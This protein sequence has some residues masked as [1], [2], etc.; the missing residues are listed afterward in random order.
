MKLEI[1]E[2]EELYKATEQYIEDQKVKRELETE[3]RKATEEAVT[4][5]FDEGFS[6]TITG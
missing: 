6:F 5:E 4:Y 3:R 2:N 1:D